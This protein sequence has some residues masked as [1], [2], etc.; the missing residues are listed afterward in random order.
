[1]TCASNYSR[2]FVYMRNVAYA[3]ALAKRINGISRNT[4][5][6]LFGIMPLDGDCFLIDAHAGDYHSNMKGID[7]AAKLQGN[8][9]KTKAKIIIYSWLPEAYVLKKCNIHLSLLQP[10]VCIKQFPVLAE[11]FAN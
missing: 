3:V 6:E 4:I 8:T 5:S 2:L 1:M 7:F 9:S 11:T 10:N